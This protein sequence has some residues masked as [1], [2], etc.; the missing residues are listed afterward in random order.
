MSGTLQRML[1][2]LL[3]HC[4]VAPVHGQMAASHPRPQVEPPTGAAVANYVDVA[5]RAGLFARST[6]GG[7]PGKHHI[8]EMTGGGVALFDFDGDGWL[9][10]FLTSTGPTDPDTGAAATN[11]LY[12]NNHD[13]TFSDVTERAGLVRHGW[14]Q[15][16][17]VGDFDG[18]GWPDLFVTYYGRN[19]LYRNQ[20]DGTFTDVTAAA[21]L[22][23][24]TDLYSTGSAFVDYDRD[25]HLDLF[26]AHYVAYSEATTHDA[27]HGDHCAWRGLTVLCGPRGLRGA[28]GTL[29]RNRGDG[30][31]QDV[32]VRAGISGALDYG[33][34]PL[35]ADFN[36]DGWPDIYVADDS[37]PSR[38]Y[39]NNHDGTFTEA[40]TLSGTAFNEDGRE[41]SGMG[42][43][44]GD[45]NGDLRLDIVKTNFEQD[46][47]TLYR[48]RADGSFDDVT[49]SS[50]L[51]VNTSF[52]GWGT[53]F[54]DF[55]NDGWPDIFMA[56]GH[57][58]EEVDAL[59]DTSYHQRKILYHNKGDGTF[60][61]VSLRAG[62]SLLLQRVSRGVASGDLF[63]TGQVDLVVNNL[64]DAPTLLCNQ[65]PAKNHALTLH[66]VGK[67]PN[68]LAIGARV[69]VTSQT[70][71]M[72]Q[73][74]R[75]GGSY[76]SQGDMRLRFGLGAATRADRVEIRWPDGHVDTLQDVAGGAIITVAYGGRI[77]DQMSY[78]ALPARLRP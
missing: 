39:M 75:S 32:S 74:V 67:N 21:G 50:G 43:D 65:M 49:F 70:H 34:T 15:G 64:A 18:D 37:T 24:A 27:D 57:I 77:V 29:Y 23:S 54:I 73:E 48:G 66:L 52:V 45:V 16:V 11:H 47:S 31:F 25:G 3:V 35:V 68:A 44:A 41:Q 33:F 60:E 61:D 40:G 1:F 55:D 5:N 46:T 22:V 7:S 6:L 56:N 36:N 53:T 20:H 9:D 10:I 78:R 19:V 2:L 76:I 62:P 38:L 14:A 51:G 12:R 42:A 28:T 30:T 4:A 58:Y 72:V 26:V 71:S 59:H 63:N 8:R 13:G 17:S 69:T